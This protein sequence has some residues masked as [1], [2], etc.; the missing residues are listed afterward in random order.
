[1]L[2]IFKIYSPKKV[3][4]SIRCQWKCILFLSQPQITHPHLVKFTGDG[5]NIVKTHMC[6]WSCGKTKQAQFVLH[7]IHSPVQHLQIYTWTIYV[8]IYSNNSHAAHTTLYGVYIWVSIKSSQH[9]NA[10]PCK[11]G[12]L[13]HGAGRHR[14]IYITPLTNL[15]L[16]EMLNTSPSFVSYILRNCWNVK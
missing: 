9:C 8:S 4:I 10:K 13:T 14:K 6:F 12:R 2:M 11:K 16:D 5:A 1:M 3:H 7:R 15:S